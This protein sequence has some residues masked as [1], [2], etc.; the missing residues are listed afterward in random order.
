MIVGAGLLSVSQ[1]VWLG[2]VLMLSGLLVLTLAFAFPRS[3]FVALIKLARKL[4]RQ[5]NLAHIEW[6]V[7]LAYAL[8]RTLVISV[9]RY[10]VIVSQY[11]LLLSA[12]SE[13]PVSLWA[14][15]GLASTVFLLKSAIPSFTLAE[16]GIR[17][18]LALLVAPL[19]GL[20]LV[21]VFNATFTL[22]LLN[23]VLPAL[24]GA[25]A[26]LWWAIPTRAAHA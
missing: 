3:L 18:G 20:P 22:F 5:L 6:E 17:E 14:S 23:L 24:A 12:F 10:L 8:R 4:P 25:G 9:L 2:I 1:T 11:G 15:V 7:P 13:M 19:F 26:L 16:L 21:P